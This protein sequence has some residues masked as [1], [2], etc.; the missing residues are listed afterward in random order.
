[1]KTIIKY[2]I[3]LAFGFSS[4][5]DFLDRVP[6]QKA[7]SEEEVFTNVD[8]YK[9]FVNQL[10]LRYS[11]FDDPDMTNQSITAYNGSNGLLVH[12]KQMYGLRE[13]ITDNMWNNESSSWVLQNRF[14]RNFTDHSPSS[15]YFGEGVSNRYATF[16]RAIRICNIAIANIDRLVDA[17]DNDI[18]YILGLAYFCRAHFYFMLLQGWGGMPYVTA[19]LDPEGEMDFERLSYTETCQMIAKDFETAATYLPLIVTRSNLGYPSKMGAIA[20]KAKALV[21]A[22]SPFANPQDDKQLWSNAAIAAGEAIKMAEESGYYQLVQFS[23]WKKLFVD[24]EEV[25][26]R[27]ILFGRYFDQIR[28]GN[29]PYMMRIQSSDNAFQTRGN[30]DQPTENLAQCFP[31]SNGEPINPDS[32]EYRSEPY[33]GWSSAAGGHNGRDPRFYQTFLFNGAVN[34]LTT[35]KGRNV[36]IW[37]KSD[38]G[39]SPRD[40]PN[41]NL[42]TGEPNRSTT[43]TGYHMFKYYSS[44]AATGATSQFNIM[45]NY[46]RLADVYLFYAEAA[47]RVWGPNGAPTGTGVAY[48]AVD[49]LNKVR[50]RANM[51]SFSAGATHTWLR[52]GSWQEFEEVIRNEVRIETAFEEKRFYDLRRWRLMQDPKVMENKGMFITQKTATTFVYTPQRMR[53]YPTRHTANWTERHY[54]FQIPVSDTR[55]G[56]KFKQNPGW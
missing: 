29:C 18:T 24:C 10:L 19:P 27:E 7:F 11:F 28:V 45:W 8:Y 31:W 13:R 49:A 17:T 32:P 25:I 48:T 2:I 3:L 51:P 38:I 12:G 14:R 56:P 21:W 6:E 42:S 22:A 23:D 50:T 37:N 30:A 35:A 39:R 53:D 43:E 15:T 9:N 55:I 1:M 4:C 40:L 36:E 26:F 33:N 52:P 34:V 54:L 16:W 47:N 44:A 5:V 20:Y 46:I 41:V